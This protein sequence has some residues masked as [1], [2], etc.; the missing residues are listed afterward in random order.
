METCI[1][2]RLTPH[3]VES[4]GYTAVSLADAADHEPREGVYTITNTYETTK[5]LKFDAHMD[6]LVDSAARAGI[7]LNVERGQIRAALRAMIE[8]ASFGGAHET[9]GDVRFRITVTA[10][11][12]DCAILSIE[13]FKPL[14]AD[15]IAR[16]VRCVTVRGSVRDNPAAKTTDWMHDRTQIEKSLPSGIYTGLLL[17]EGS[18]IL[19]GLS[20]NFYAVVDGALY[21]AD[22]GVLPGISRQI[23]YAVAPR[24]LEVCK[25][26]VR[27]DDIPLVREAFITSSSR[28]IVPVVEI[29]GRRI[30]DGLPGVKTMAIRH[31]YL[32][33]MRDHLEE[34]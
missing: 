19:E 23:V 31:E 26:P 12:P 2:Q 28:G 7:A 18:A 30:G 22:E 34:L 16:G 10:A 13:P 32:G 25:T 1:I 5:V 27:V 29:D 14:P 11:A 3:G 24:V 17:S 33:W 15:L 9:P 6:R 8:A 4:V 20:S 21:T